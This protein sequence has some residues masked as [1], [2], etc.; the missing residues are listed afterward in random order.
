[1]ISKIFQFV[2]GWSNANTTSIFISEDGEVCLAKANG[3]SHK[4]ELKMFTVDKSFVLG[5]YFWTIF[6][7]SYDNKPQG[8]GIQTSGQGANIFLVNDT[9]IKQDQNDQ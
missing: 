3:T 5:Q 6:P 2:L 4:L 7:L 9:I 1:M 8:L